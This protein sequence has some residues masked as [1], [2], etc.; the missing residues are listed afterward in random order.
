MWTQLFSIITTVICLV[1]M[2]RKFQEG[3][4]D[5]KYTGITALV[6]WLI[7]DITISVSFPY[8]EVIHIVFQSL[9]L[10]F[11]LIIFLIFIRKR[12]PVIFRNP[13]YMVFIPLLIP[14]AQAIVL[15]THLMKDI[16]FM[17]IQ[18]VCIMVFIFLSIGYSKELHH[19]LFAIIGAILLLWGFAF[20]WI[21]QEYFIVFEWA[22]GLTNMLG[23]VAS[24]YAFTD[25]LTDN[26]IQI[27]T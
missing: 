22:W 3:P 18:A 19:K 9:S 13:Y 2:I 5:I 26:E 20:Y 14:L 17:S 23:M 1:I 7:G 15:E 4:S 24:V 11:V 6:A 25:L 16:V 12:K 10:S 8:Q 21:L 27:T